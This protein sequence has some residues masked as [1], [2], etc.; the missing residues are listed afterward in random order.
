MKTVGVIEIAAGLAGRVCASRGCVC[1]RALARPASSSA[2]DAQDFD[3]VALREFG[4]LEGALALG[5]LAAIH[6]GAG[7]REVM[8]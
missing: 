3:D 4:L 1:C 2:C 6:G 5:S 7:D 8:T